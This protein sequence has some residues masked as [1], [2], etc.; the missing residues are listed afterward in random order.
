MTELP[1]SMIDL[2]ED[3]GDCCYFRRSFQKGEQVE[4]RESVTG[5]ANPGVKGTGTALEQSKSVEIRKSDDENQLILSTQQLQRS[6]ADRDL[7][8]PVPTPAS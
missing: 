8:I 6:G 7:P 5:V 4:L 1:D 2:P 3:I